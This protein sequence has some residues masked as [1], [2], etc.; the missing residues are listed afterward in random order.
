MIKFSVLIPTRN[1]L[2]YLKHA[3]RS[4]LRQDY[5]HWEIVVSDNDSEEDIKGY[6][7]SLADPR[8][9]YSR[10]E[11]FLSVTENWN[12]ALVNSGGDYIIMMGDDDCLLQGYFNQTSDLIK[13][14]QFPDLLY[15]S[16]Y[17]YAYPNVFPEHP[18]GFLQK[19]GNA[20]F[21]E[22]K[23]QPF[24]LKK[25]EA[26][27]AVKAAMNFKVIFNFNMQFAL[28]HRSLIPEMQKKGEFFQSPYPDYYAMTALLL[29]AKR[30]LAVPKPLVVIG[31]TP[32]SFGYYYFNNKEKEG[33]NFL[34]NIPENIS[35]KVKN[36]LLPGS[37][38]N[39][40]WLLSFEMIRN[41]FNNEFHVKPAYHRYRLLQVIHHLKRFSSDQSVQANDFVELSNN[42]HFWEKACYLIPFSLASYLMRKSNRLKVKM[43]QWMINLSHPQYTIK[44]IDGEFRDISEVL[45]KFS[46]S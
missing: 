21:L 44:K 29:I 23:D 19:W 42:L 16:A 38:M 2:E 25:E 46:E 18:Q 14:Y 12:R 22:G 8:I 17:L 31:I 30:I 13:T 28:F 26:F 5:D 1:R 4:V 36:R 35:M 9:K 39:T 41:N 32:K 43:M 6:V 24:L 10:T 45:D 11:K 20:L 34:N 40:F 27:N 3:I 33:N 7:A 37:D 15:C